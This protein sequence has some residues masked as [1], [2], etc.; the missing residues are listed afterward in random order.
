MNTHITRTQTTKNKIVD[1]IYSALITIHFDIWRLNVHSII[2]CFCFFVD[3]DLLTIT[4]LRRFL[5]KCAAFH[6]FEV[7]FRFMACVSNIKYIDRPFGTFC[8]SSQ[9]C[10]RSLSFCSPPTI[11]EDRVPKSIQRN[12]DS[13][14]HFILNNTPFSIRI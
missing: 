14:C 5:C 13:L 12:I 8:I 11:F 9:Y 1:K 7:E 6:F 2:F 10:R 3:Q 4:Y